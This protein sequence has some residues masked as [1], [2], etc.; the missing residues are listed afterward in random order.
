[1]VPYNGQA[2]PYTV[3]FFIVRALARRMSKA[4]DKVDEHITQNPY[5]TLFSPLQAGTLT[6]P[7]RILMGSMHMGLE[8]LEDG[9]A[10]LAAFYAERARGGVALIVTGG[11]A[12]NEEG[13][14]VQGGAKLTCPEELPPHRL[15][16]AAVH[17]AGSRIALQ[18]LHTGRYA[19]NHAQVA[20]SAIQAR[21][22][23][24]VP[25]AMSEADIHRTIAD[26]AQ[27]AVLA[28]EA[29]YDG[30]EIMGSEGYLLNQFTAPRTNHR[31][32]GWGGDATRRRRFPV[33]VAQAVRQAVGP[34]FLVIYRLSLLDLVEDGSTWEETQLLA[35]EL[36]RAGVDLFNTGIGWHEA[37]IPTIMTMVPRAA[38]AWASARLKAAV[39]I[40]VVASNRINTPEV[41]E[42]VLRQGQADMVS[43]A[44]P[45]LADA[46]LPTKSAKGR[47]ASINV[48]I[49]C[50]QACLDHS[51]S[52]KP[53]SCL[54]NPRAG[55]ET[56]HPV[57]PAKAPLSVAIVGGGPAGLACAETAARRGHRVTLFERD[58][59]L[60]GQFQ[61]AQR[62]PGKADYGDTI[63][64][65]EHS[66]GELGV[67]IRRH[68]E[69]DEDMLSSGFDTVILATGVQ[70][71][72]PD[73]QGIHL[74]HVV[75]YP[76]A[77]DGREL[78]ERLVIIGGGGIAIDMAHYATLRDLDEDEQALYEALWGIDRSPTRRG[79]LNPQ[80][81]RPRSKR[82]VTMLQRS[83]A[84]IGR[85]LGRTTAWAHRVALQHLGVEVLTGVGFQIIDE[86]G[87]TITDQSGGSRRIAADQVLLCAGQEAHAPLA[88]PLRARGIPVHLIGGARDADHL[89]AKRAIEEA[90]L[91]ACSL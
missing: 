55:R 24:F 40:P 61:L 54:V 49:A 85:A 78:G 48:C 43:M 90:F 68:T 9:F 39:S 70:P 19:F 29:G 64:Y 5:P 22:N 26:Y 45:M 81:N 6:L 20:P 87:V 14:V 57:T 65:F 21:I 35:K 84:V 7:N 86:H 69:P 88:A 46:E 67:T 47:T 34:D 37:R 31:D 74:A 12:P 8:E 36:E 17:E 50:N 18:L 62:I 63:A 73:I 59:V 16:T 66:L 76:H 27:A 89:D 51:F 32:D 13:A 77:L 79:G 53:A 80:P 52:G 42:A 38:F 91:L 23:P 83:P 72:I 10:R 58:Q 30:V 60:G 75:P 4:I 25:R 1:M 28:R 2:S 71:R 56:T 3:G 33:A 11:V 15:V 41:A 82:Q 44:R